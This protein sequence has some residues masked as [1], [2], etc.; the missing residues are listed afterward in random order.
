VTYPV[1]AIVLLYYI[2]CCS[3][4]LP[5]NAQNQKQEA[6]LA[7]RWGLSAKSEALQTP[8]SRHY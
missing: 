2:L 7:G 5:I 6:F 1:K 4:H 8:T 3:I